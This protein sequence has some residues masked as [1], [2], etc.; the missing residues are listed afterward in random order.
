M[1][2][3]Q[4]P[5]FGCGGSAEEG[6]RRLLAESRRQLPL[7]A[8]SPPP[9]PACLDCCPARGKRWAQPFQVKESSCW[10]NFTSETNVGFSIQWVYKHFISLG[11]PCLRFAGSR[12]WAGQCFGTLLLLAGSW[13]ACV[14]QRNFSVISDLVSFRPG[15]RCTAL[16][17]FMGQACHKKLT[18][19]NNFSPLPLFTSHLP[20]QYS[21]RVR[22]G[23]ERHEKT[24]RKSSACKTFGVGCSICFGCWILN[25][26]VS[27]KVSP[28]RCFWQKWNSVSKPPSDILSSVISTRVDW[29]S[30]SYILNATSTLHG[31]KGWRNT[32]EIMCVSDIFKNR[33][34]CGQ[35]ERS[36]RVS[37][38]GA[39]L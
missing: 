21:Q 35:G 36:R 3:Q 14:S 9:T 24:V 37:Q 32:Q 16:K 11:S 5:S 6:Q 12:P 22:K 8:P 15:V 10:G 30:N 17:S 38:Q 7:P 34:W 29:R 26:L 4:C 27:N 1:Q 20:S 23:R 18:A 39:A 25:H 33:V 28:Q 13:T 19:K 2:A 31:N